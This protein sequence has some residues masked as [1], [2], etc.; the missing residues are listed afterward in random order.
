MY[1][2][3]SNTIL[4]EAMKN[5]MAG[6]MVCAYQFLID[7]LHAHGIRPKHHVLGNKILA[8]L[9]LAIEN[10]EM[11]YQLVSPDDHRRTIA[12]KGIQTAKGHII[13]VLCRAAS[14][15]SMRLWDRLLL[16]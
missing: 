2:M 4:M 9:K 15:F 10:N 1:E 16:G 11:N 8:E 5:W 7:R 14:K 12:K 6:K 3:D 13:F